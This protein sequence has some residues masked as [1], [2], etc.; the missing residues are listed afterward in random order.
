MC[1]HSVSIY[2]V[3]IPVPVFDTFQSKEEVWYYSVSIYTVDVPVS[4]FDT[5]LSIE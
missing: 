5:F 3:D 2:T 1:Y 4:V